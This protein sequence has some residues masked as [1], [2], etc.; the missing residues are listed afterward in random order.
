MKRLIQYYDSQKGF[1]MKTIV[2]PIIILLVSLVFT[3]VVLLTLLILGIS[4]W[5]MLVSI[6]LGIEALV[7]TICVVIFKNTWKKVDN[8][9]H[10]LVDFTSLWAMI[11]LVLF[12]HVLDGRREYNIYSDLD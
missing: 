2:A 3:L 7:F 11:L 5:A 9:Y 10:A 4:G 12:D 1:I 8:I 6:L